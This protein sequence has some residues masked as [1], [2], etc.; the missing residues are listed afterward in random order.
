MS[1]TPDRR[2]GF[3]RGAFHAPDS[4]LAVDKPCRNRNLASVPCES[5]SRFQAGH[6]CRDPWAATLAP[7]LP[8]V[9]PKHAYNPAAKETFGPRALDALAIGWAPHRS[10][11]AHILWTNYAH[12]RGRMPQ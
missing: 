3:A 11:A 6:C 9:A 12:L 7:A 10:V 8:A 2:P 4:D 5:G 1:E